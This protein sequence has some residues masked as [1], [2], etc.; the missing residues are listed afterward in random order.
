MSITAGNEELLRL[1]ELLLIGADTVRRIAD[2]RVL[3][4]DE[5]YVIVARAQ[6]TAAEIRAICKRAAD[7]SRTAN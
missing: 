2:T 3:D 4:R 6:E 1:A 7:A 5:L